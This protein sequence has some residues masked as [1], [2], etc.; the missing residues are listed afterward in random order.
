MVDY[1]KEKR[2]AFNM[3]DKLL[4]EGVNI[5]IIYFKIETIYGFSKK[6][7][8]SRLESLKKITDLTKKKSK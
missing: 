1:Y 8:D 7:V 3:I 6:L 5:E 4:S 2:M